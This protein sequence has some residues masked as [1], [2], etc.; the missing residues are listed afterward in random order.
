MVSRNGLASAVKMLLGEGFRFTIIGGTVV[1]LRLGS[2]D[3]GDDV[4]VFAEHPSV[5]VDEG[6]YYGLESRGW[7]VGQTWLGTPRVIVHVNNEDVPVEFYDNLYDFY[8]PEEV[9]E[10][11]ERVNLSGVRVKIIG[12]EDH[13]VLKAN[14]GRGSDLERLKEIARHIKRGRLRVDKRRI[15][16]TASLFDD[17][18]VI[19][20]RLKDSG[21]PV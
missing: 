11:A 18:V 20:R 17:E 5:L 6:V 13:I 8:V 15:K 19:L 9:I 2:R 3:L 7:I 10:S 4:D 1:E 14:A 21:I 12:L 16:E